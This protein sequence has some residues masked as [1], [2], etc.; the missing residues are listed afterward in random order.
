L[1]IKLQMAG[2]PGTRCTLGVR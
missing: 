1:D 2:R